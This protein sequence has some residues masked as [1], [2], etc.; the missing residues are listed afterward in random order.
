MRTFFSCIAAALLAF[1]SIFLSSCPALAVGNEPLKGGLEI[2]AREVIRQINRSQ[3][4]E[5]TEVVPEGLAVVVGS[6]NSPPS[7]KAA[8]GPGIT[9]LLQD[10]LVSMGV[11][12][13]GPQA[14]QVTGRV[15]KE[16]LAENDDDSFKQPAITIT[17]VLSDSSGSDLASVK[18]NVFGDAP[19]QFIGGTGT[20]PVSVEGKPS[21]E[22]AQAIE[23]AIQ[24]PTTS[25]SDAETRPAADSPFGVEVLVAGQARVPS[26]IDGRS[27]VDLSRGEE[28]SVRLH[29]QSDKEIAVT[30]TIDGINM[31]AFS[32]FGDFSGQV[33]VPPQSHITVPG[34]VITT[35]K[36][37]A[38]T[39]TG[40]AESAA[41]ELL[42]SDRK[43]VV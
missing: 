20:L 25:L 4:R 24:E 40:Y 16:T 1:A 39:I 19:L 37:D 14:F 6:F 38:F 30:L 13:E 27:F 22:R 29:N 3:G 11:Q 28:Y 34:W 10:A 41:K 17:A 5:P 8:G 33:L 32:E 2:V 26:V 15:S 21:P 43:S 35:T 23:D 31:F 42:V 36:T 7:L 12:S 18:H 9:Q